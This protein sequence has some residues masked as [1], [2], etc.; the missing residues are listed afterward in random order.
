MKLKCL[1]VFFII[2]ESSE[3]WGGSFT[4]IVL[5]SS[6]NYREEESVGCYLTPIL[7]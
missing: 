7:R 5:D 3:S 4:V 6:F 1:C 2:I